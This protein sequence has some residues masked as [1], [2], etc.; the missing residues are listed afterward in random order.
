[1]IVSPFDR[2]CRRAAFSCGEPT[3]DGYLRRQVSQDIRNRVASC[4]VLHESGEK[5]I[6]GYYTLAAVSAYLSEIPPDLARK[7][8]KYPHVPMVLLGRLAV[9]GKFKGKGA[10]GLLLADAC[11]RALAASGEI[12]AWAVA[13]D[14]LHDEARAFYRKYGFLDLGSRKM[15]LPMKDIKANL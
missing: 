10:G 5:E 11:K 1:M 7:L 14:P 15:F 3:L 4:F 2:S 9:D 12:A 6:I 8:P 13:V